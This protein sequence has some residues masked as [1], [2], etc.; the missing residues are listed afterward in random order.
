MMQMSDWMSGLVGAVIFLL[1]L[2]PI[3]G[4][5]DFANDLS[6]T[7]LTWIVAISGFYLLVNSV[8]EITNSNIVGWWSFGV[9]V[10][11]II[12]GFFPILHGFGIGPSFFEFSWLSRSSYN[13]IFVIEGLFLMVATFAMEL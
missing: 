8:V 9:A 2:M 7:L 10:A 5:W 1:G 3:L 12:I 4:R 13:F 11:V 6:I